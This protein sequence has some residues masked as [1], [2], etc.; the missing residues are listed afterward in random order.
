MFS[1]L[2]DFQSQNVLILFLFS[3]KNPYLLMKETTS[4]DNNSLSLGILEI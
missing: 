2:L 1:F 4:Y 3:I